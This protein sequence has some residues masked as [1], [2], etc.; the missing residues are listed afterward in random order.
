MRKSK[1]RIT[2][3]VN[4]AAHENYWTSIYIHLIDSPDPILTL[5][6]RNDE[7]QSLPWQMEYQT[8]LP[9]Q[10]IGIDILAQPRIGEALEKP[11]GRPRIHVEVDSTGYN[12][13][14]QLIAERTGCICFHEIF[15]ANRPTSSL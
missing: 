3:R 15:G 9:V 13:T 10:A 6:F 14:R 11:G 4:Y 8:H 1:F 2:I 12:H 5:A 7:S